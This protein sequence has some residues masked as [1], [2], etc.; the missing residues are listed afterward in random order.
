MLIESG[1]ISVGSIRGVLSGKHYN[2][3]IM[4]HKLVYEALQR[5][6]FDAYLDSIDNQQKES[7]A[8]SIQNVADC[9]AN[10]KLIDCIESQQMEQLVSNY[11]QFVE[12]SSTKSKTF[13]FWSMYIKMTGMYYIPAC[14]SCKPYIIHLCAAQ[15]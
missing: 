7:V 12:K 1:I 4:C 15:M 2:R 9:F 11:E 3:S 13:A 10:G 14:P 6:R 5:L 8:T